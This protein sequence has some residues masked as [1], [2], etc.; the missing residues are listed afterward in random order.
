M[1]EKQ[2][3]VTDDRGVCLSVCLAVC[4]AAQLG[5]TMQKWLYGSAVRG[6]SGCFRAILSWSTNVGR[7][8]PSGTEAVNKSRV[9]RVHV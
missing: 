6:Y 7:R 8:Q 2:T 1:H 9:T 3:V 5:F 4:H